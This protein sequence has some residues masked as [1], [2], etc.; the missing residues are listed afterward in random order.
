MTG[1]IRLPQCVSSGNSYWMVHAC[2]SAQANPSKFEHINVS[3]HWIQKVHR[4]KKRIGT[5][6]VL[7]YPV[8]SLSLVQRALVPEAPWPLTLSAC[9]SH[10]RLPFSAGPVKSVHSAF[11]EK[12]NLYEPPGDPFKLCHSGHGMAYFQEDCLFPPSPSNI[13]ILIS[14]PKGC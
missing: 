8:S 6:Q 1:P 13:R 7:F 9:P 10:P 11:S 12:E 4:M 2:K 14:A 5:H 3:Y